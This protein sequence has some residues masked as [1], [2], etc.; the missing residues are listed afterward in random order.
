[1]LC[2]HGLSDCRHT[3]YCAD[4]FKIVSTFCFTYVLLLQLSQ[5]VGTQSSLQA[6]PRIG[7][8]YALLVGECTA[9]AG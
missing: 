3:F 9:H 2:G 8:V 1:M 5:E 7:D 4:K 6:G